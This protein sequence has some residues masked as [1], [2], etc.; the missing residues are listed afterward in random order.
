MYRLW[1]VEHVQ[2]LVID[3]I[4]YDGLGWGEKK[5]M[6]TKKE[7]VCAWIAASP[8]CSNENEPPVKSSRMF[9]ID[10]PTVDFRFQF[11]CAC[12]MYLMTV[13]PNLM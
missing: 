7:Y 1:V 2:A 10:H 5:K 4:K 9:P 12:G 11:M 3:T 6:M 8:I 13:T